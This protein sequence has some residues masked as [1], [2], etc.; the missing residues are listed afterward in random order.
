MKQ[1]QEEIKNSFGESSSR[2]LM[3]IITFWTQRIVDSNLQYHALLAGGGK[4]MGVRKL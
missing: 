4:G 3:E 1:F 2:E